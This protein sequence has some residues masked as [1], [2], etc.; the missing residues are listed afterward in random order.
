MRERSEQAEKAEQSEQARLF[1]GV[2]VSLAT[3][4]A[5]AATAEL[6]RARAADLGLGVRWVAPTRYHITLT[7]LGWTRASAIEAIRDVLTRGL[8]GFPE[9]EIACRGLGAFPDPT[10]ARVLWAGVEDAS[11]EL[12]R[13]AALVSELLG[14]LGFGPDEQRTFQ[15]HVTLGRVEPPS[16]VSELLHAQSGQ[17][18]RQSRVDAVV[19][20]DSIMKTRGPEYVARARFPLGNAPQ[21]T[22]RHT[23]PLQPQPDASPNGAASRF[24]GPGESQEEAL[25]PDGP[26]GSNV[27]DRPDVQSWPNT[28]DQGTGG[29]GE[30]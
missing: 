4:G 11:G 20:Y 10:A 23:G 21:R 28:N 24:G 2:D 9:L 18:F 17:M 13:L 8:T 1:V 27:L 14:E 5:L 12:A 22:K 26:E 3:V 16:D 6:L 25:S 29:E 30:A 19:L 15:P 7:Y